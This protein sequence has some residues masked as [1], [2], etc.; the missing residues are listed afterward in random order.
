[1]NCLNQQVL[2]DLEQV[3]HAFSPQECN[4]ITNAV[5]FSEEICESIAKDDRFVALDG[6]ADISLRHW[7][8]KKALFEWYSNLSI[9]LAHK[10][11]AKLSLQ[12]LLPLVNSLRNIGQWDIPPVEIIDFGRIYGFM[13]Q[14]TIENSFVFPTAQ[15]LFSKSDSTIGMFGLAIQ[16]MIDIKLPTISSDYSPFEATEKIFSNVSPR[17]RLVIESREGLSTGRGMTLEETANL[18]PGDKKLT[19]ERIRQIEAK[20]WRSILHP[21]RVRRA[22]IILLKDVME[23]HGSLIEYMGSPE[24]AARIF[25]V[26]CAGIP[27]AQFPHTEIVVIGVNQEDVFEFESS[28]WYRG[29]PDAMATASKIESIGKFSLLD[30]DIAIIAEDIFDYSKSHQTKTEKVLIALKRIGKPSHYT[31]IAEVYHSIFPNDHMSLHAIHA[32]LGKEE[33]G[34][35]WIGIRGTFALSEWGYEHPSKGLFDSVT[36]IVNDVYSKTHQPVP[37]QMIVTE[38]G[39]YRKVAR[40]TSITIAATCN[41]YVTPVE[42]HCFVPA[43]ISWGEEVQEAPA[44]LDNLLRDFE[45]SKNADNEE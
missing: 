3:K 6:Q 35:V 10:K 20:F 24:S 18:L 44:D 4:D 21:V 27:F 29:E 17:T 39:R 13:G 12:E 2:D 15:V 8:P 26:R 1:M 45:Q 25:I 43:N 7:I 36:E 9:D 16:D 33:H 30:N 23:H 41:P 11:Q 38:M 28:E 37:F 40:L 32:L 19:R 22:L 14:G 42:N 34:V 31:S 5:T